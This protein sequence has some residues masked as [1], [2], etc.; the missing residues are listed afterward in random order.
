[1]DKREALC[2][3]REKHFLEIQSSSAT[4]QQMD[5]PA[6]ILIIQSKV[7]TIDAQRKLI[8]RLKKKLEPLHDKRNRINLEGMIVFYNNNLVSTSSDLVGKVINGLSKGYLKTNST[9]Y[10][11]LCYIVRPF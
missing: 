1:L 6:L 7:Q 3:E 2:T 11:L 8:D 4:H 10:R 5:K 9:A